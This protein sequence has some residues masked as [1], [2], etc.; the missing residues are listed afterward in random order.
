M[1][2]VRV[3]VQKIESV[4]KLSISHFLYKEVALSMIS[5]ELP[6]ALRDAREVTLGFNAMAVGVAK[7]DKAELSY[8]NQ[9]KCSLK[10][11][12]KGELLSELLL[13]FYEDEFCS[14][15]TTESLERLSLREGDT[16]VALIKANELFVVE[17]H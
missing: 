9:L 15:I 14:I 10:K 16:L 7:G 1:N 4:E 8:S 17:V 13:S 3:R 12:T 11:I 2:R 5:L 6:S